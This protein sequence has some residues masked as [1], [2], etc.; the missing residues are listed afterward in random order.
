M[1]TLL[2]TRFLTCFLLTGLMAPSVCAQPPTGVI[3]T[4]IMPFP[5]SQLGF[6]LGQWFELH[7]TSEEVADLVGCE[8]QI[9]ETGLGKTFV[10]SESLPLDPSGF[11][12]VGLTQALALNGGIPMD[13]AIGLDMALPQFGGFLRL[14]CQDQL[15]DE[16]VYGPNG[17]LV[18]QEGISLALEPSAQHSQTNDDLSRWCNSVLPIPGTLVPMFGSPS[19]PSTACDSDGDGLTEDQGDCDDS[20]A[21]VRPGMWERCNGI[22]DNC[23]D[24]K[25]ES[26]RIDEPVISTIGACAEN[27]PICLGSAGYGWEETGGYEPEEVTCDGVDNDCDGLVDE[28]MLNACGTCGVLPADECDGDDNDCDG[29]I[30]EDAVPPQDFFCSGQG[31]GVCLNVEPLCSGQWG[32]SYP[33]G[34]QFE[35][36]WCDGLDNDCDG[37]TDEGFGLGTP[38]MAGLGSCLS[39]G[40]LACDADPL[41]TRCDAPIIP[42]SAELCGDDE[43]N[44]CDGD[45]DEGFF[46]GETCFSGEGVCRTAGKFFC[47]SDGLT[48]VC[49]AV[50]L[51]P[52]SEIC[53]NDQDDDC[54]GYVDEYPC[55][56]AVDSTLTGCSASKPE[57]LFCVKSAFPLSILIGVVF[58][59]LWVLGRWGLKR[60]EQRGKGRPR[61]L[62][63][64][65]R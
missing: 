2:A 57:G 36:T 46:L 49:S 4:E 45:V 18:P 50:P 42:P 19:A 37:Q 41:M 53:G 43:D 47:S 16:V 31:L 65:D 23:N 39:Q 33:M 26:P 6:P 5:P 11:L 35:E 59:I 15:I 30:D 22:D 14:L 21:M 38:C 48:Y 40:R 54:D 3:F 28:E 32:C 51:A 55:I 13:V 58:G 8:I 9:G 27:M 10:V 25:D 7:N 60:L 20:Q 62:E 1:R 56:E 61:D 44:D 64:E 12:I 34:H 63:P 17:G 24:I 29:Q 52:G